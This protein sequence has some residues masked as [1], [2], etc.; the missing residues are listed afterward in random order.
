MLWRPRDLKPVGFDGV[1]DALRGS[2]FTGI[3]VRTQFDQLTPAMLGEF[4]I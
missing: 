1:S 3:A 4:G 2:S